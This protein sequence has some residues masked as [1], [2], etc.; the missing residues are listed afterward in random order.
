M[1]QTPS[2][3]DINDAIDPAALPGTILDAHLHTVRGAADSALQPDDLLTEARRIGLTGINISEHDRVWERYDW[4]VFREQCGGIYLNQGMEVS[5]DL[6]HI[7]VFG[8]DQYYSGIRSAERLREVCDE[9]GAFMSVAHPFRHFF[10]PVTFRRKGEEPFAMSPE[11]AAEKMHVFQVVHGIEVGNGGNT[12]RENIFALEV[13][14]ILNKPVTGGSDAHS[15]S[16][17]GTY[18]TVFPEPLTCREQTV[19]LLHDGATVCYE[20]LNLNQ[21]RPFEKCAGD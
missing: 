5:T 13:A 19:Q 21:F 20:G 17:I 8:I 10:D 7:V 15:T 2:S 16:G 11:E 14:Q 18:T 4:N 1:D 9:I 12:R 6:G 3:D